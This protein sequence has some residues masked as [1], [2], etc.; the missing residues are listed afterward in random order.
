[1][2][3]PLLHIHCVN[4]PFCEY[5]TAVKVAMDDGSV[6]TYVLENKMQFMFEQVMKSL[7]RMEVGY[8]YEPKHSRRKNRIHRWNDEHGRK[9]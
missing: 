4:E 9:G 5:P 8:Q 3:K 7:D 1:M 6:Q 2:A